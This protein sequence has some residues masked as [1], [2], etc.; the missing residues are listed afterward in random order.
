MER[1]VFTWN[2]VDSVCDWMLLDRNGN[3]QGPIERGG[4]LEALTSPAA[5]REVIWLLPGSDVI[6]LKANVPVK[7]RERLARALPF[8]LEENLAEDPEHMFFALPGQIVEGDTETVALQADSLRRGLATLSAHGVSPHRIVPDYLTLPRVE[9]SWTI[10]ADA[11]MLYVRTGFADGFTLETDAA[12]LILL[13]R[14]ETLPEEAR[15]TRLCLFRGREPV[16]AVPEIA[17][18]EEAP[19]PV[20]E[21]LL[22][23]AP[24]ALAAGT[25]INLLQGSFNP[26]RQWRKQLRPWWPAAA[27]LTAVVL[28]AL[29]NFAAGWVH[30]AGQARELH[31][32]V[33]AQFHAILPN[34]PIEDIRGQVNQRLQAISSHDSNHGLLFLLTALAQANTDST[35]IESLSYQPGTLQ[36]QIHAPDVTT[37]EAL[38]AGI[39]SH[40]ALPVTIRSANQTKS[41]VE[42]SLSIGQGNAQ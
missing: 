30:D 19:E 3:R 12:W 16:G 6:S 1:L 31:R 7:T 17:A 29:V 10:L 14:F 24:Q 18:L 22:G 9:N 23:L 26:K 38:R 13:R 42:G 35:R 32:A 27:A 8:A 15:P 40:S 20:P 4:E 11:G 25:P 28:M 41:G 39:A 33:V 37:L 36:V 34:Q 21:G 2:A 5:R